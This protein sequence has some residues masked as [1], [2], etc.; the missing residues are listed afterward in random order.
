MLIELCEKVYEIQSGS[1]DVGVSNV[2]HVFLA[3]V[4]LDSDESRQRLRTVSYL[5]LPKTTPGQV[6]SWSKQ[7]V[8]CIT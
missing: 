2:Q 5:I 8:A 3:L 7:A 4:A 6:N 1:Y